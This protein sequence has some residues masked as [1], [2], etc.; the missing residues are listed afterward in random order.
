MEIP[1]VVVG[2]FPLWALFFI[3]SSGLVV[4]VSFPFDIFQ[5]ANFENGLTLQNISTT[6]HTIINNFTPFINLKYLDDFPIGF[7]KIT[8]TAFVP[9]WLSIS[10][11]MFIVI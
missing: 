2:K 3:L 8:I 5:F 7:T 11:K 4:V 1:K 6:P 10:L 9:G